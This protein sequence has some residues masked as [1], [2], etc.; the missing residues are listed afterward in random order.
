MPR[1][2]IGAPVAA[3]ADADALRALALRGGLLVV[4]VPRQLGRHRKAANRRRE[5]R[6]QETV[7]SEN[8]MLTFVCDTSA[9]LAAIAKLPIASENCVRGEQ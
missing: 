1:G 9:S 7:P 5:L 6:A 3:R 4:Q 2:A 8:E